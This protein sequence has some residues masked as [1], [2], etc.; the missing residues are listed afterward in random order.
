MVEIE[1]VGSTIDRSKH[2]VLVVD[3]NPATLYSTSRTLRAAGFMTKEAASG[4]EALSI[5]GDE[6][7]SAVVL[8]VHLPDM[9]GF[10]VC[11]KLRESAKTA[12]LPVI[13][14]SATYIADKDKVAGFN[15]GADAYLT[16]PAEPPILIAT[17]QALIRA[18]LAEDQLRKSEAKFRAIYTQAE[19]GIALIDESGLFVDANPALLRMLGRNSEEVIGKKIVDFA[20][21]KW[22]SAVKAL[23]DKEDTTA[24]EWRETFA[25]SLPNGEEVYLE[26]TMST[27]VEP[28]LRVGIVSNISARMSFEQQRES[29]LEREKVARTSAEQL[30]Q[31]KDNFIAV[32]SHE[33]RNPLNAILMGLH[34]LLRKGAAPD[35]VKGLRMI[36]R[37]AKAQAR[38]I[39]DILDVSRINSGKLTLDRE[40]IDPA[41]VIS[42]ALEGMKEAIDKRQLTVALDVTSPPELV[43]L[44]PTRIQQIFWNIL[45]NAIKF[46][47]PGGAIEVT[48]TKADNALTLSVQDHGKGI[49]PEFLKTIFDKF[50]QGDTPGNRSHGGLGLGMS[51]VKHLAEL[52]G[53]SVK[54]ESDGLGMGAKVTVGI[55]ALSAPNHSAGLSVD[56]TKLDPD[57]DSN[58][59]GVTILVVEDEPQNREMLSVILRDRGALVL[60]AENY[61]EAIQSLDG[62]LP[63]LLLSDIGLPGR[64]GYELVKEIRRREQ[65]NAFPR[66]PAIAL[67][68]FGRAQDVDK[69]IESGF[70]AHLAK[71]LRAH[72][73]V[74]LIADLTR[75]SSSHDKNALVSLT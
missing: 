10:E 41:S 9:D 30:S 34:V 61:D 35:T 15:S 49:D 51:I 55:P 68:A 7:I 26:W 25:L 43:W 38:I 17:V 12:V 69:A 37:N 4:N 62:K 57:V 24:T 39:S 58:L 28:G 70:D 32:L 23:V 29:L 19:S 72:E 31:T 22:V 36:E 52:H 60:T 44:D 8:D 63:S 2:T 1:V 20:I 54:V 14:L 27:H 11:R 5:S 18:R 71:P 45:N 65:Q 66:L 6:S 74:T 42:S 53:G 73:L 48:L 75:S 47:E 67:T 21:P 50:S 3:D 16:H 46:S 64:D 13:H 40:L 56:S 59:T 33:L